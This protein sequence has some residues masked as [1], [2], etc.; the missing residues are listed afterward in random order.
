[1][2]IF[3]KYMDSDFWDELEFYRFSIMMFTLT[4]STCIGSVA[5]CYLFEQKQSSYFIPL[6]LVVILCM[7]SN[8]A[9]I[10]QSPIKWVVSSFLLASISSVFFIFYSFFI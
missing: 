1:M 9:A 4:F 8:V 5:V 6:T 7:A 10:S 3:K 2:T